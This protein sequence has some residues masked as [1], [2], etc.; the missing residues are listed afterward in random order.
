MRY[1]TIHKVTINHWVG[2]NV[3]CLYSTTSGLNS[4]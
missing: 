2:G 3:Q 4:L 1:Q